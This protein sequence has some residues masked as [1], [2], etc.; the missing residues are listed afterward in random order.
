MQLMRYPNNSVK[1]YTLKY[2]FHR[3]DCTWTFNINLDQRE[4]K[5]SKA[6]A[7]KNKAVDCGYIQFR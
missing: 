3:M 2:G 7:I 4:P 6:T 5:F 1:K